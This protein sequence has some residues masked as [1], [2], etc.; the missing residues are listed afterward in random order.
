MRTRMLLAAVLL[1]SAR[2][3][4]YAS[5]ASARAGL[6]VTRAARQH[7]EP[8]DAKRRSASSAREREGSKIDDCQKAPSPI[9]PAKNELIWGAISFVVL[10][11]LLWKFA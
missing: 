1:A 3:C 11:V 9:L 5:V 2:C 4:S 6:A 7:G 10:F 8:S